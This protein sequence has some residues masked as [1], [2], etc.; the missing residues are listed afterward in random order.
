MAKV[1]V[2][3]MPK[4]E[5]LDPQGRAVLGAL[6]SLGFHEVSDCRMGKVIRLAIAGVSDA[7]DL[8]AMATEMAKALLANPVTEDFDVS[9]EPED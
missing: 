8:R 6:K 4:P 5:V 3:V 7:A 1:S 9:V 2:V